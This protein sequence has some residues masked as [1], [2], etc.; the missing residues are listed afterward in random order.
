MSSQ[1]IV[2]VADKGDSKHGEITV[3]DAAGKAVS[4]VETLLEAGFEQ[5]RISVFTGSGV[6]MTVTYRPVVAL[7]GAGDNDPGASPEPSDHDVGAVVAPAAAVSTP[8][9][10]PAQQ[11]AE[12]VAASAYM[13]GGVTFSSQFRPN[14]IGASVGR[15]RRSGVSAVS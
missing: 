1:F 11:P 2:L 13:R 9:D 3:L 7:S 5:E 8:T 6:S 4:L 12:P 14:A 10:G 15:V